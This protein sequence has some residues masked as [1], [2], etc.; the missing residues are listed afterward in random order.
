ME[1]TWSKPIAHHQK[2]PPSSMQSFVIS[3]QQILGLRNLP[4]LVNQIN[5]LIYYIY[6]LLLLWYKLNKYYVHLV[7]ESK[8]GYVDVKSAES[9]G[10]Y[11]FVQISN[12]NTPA[13]GVLRYDNQVFNSGGGMNLKT[14]VFTAPKAGVYTFSFSISKNGFSIDYLEIFLRL[15]GSIIGG[16]GVGIGPSANS[17]AMQSTLKLTKGDRIDLWKSKHGE[18]NQECAYYCHHF[19]G[20]LINPIIASVASL[21]SHFFFYSGHMYPIVVLSELSGPLRRV[22]GSRLF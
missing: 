8:L 17:A 21:I 22:C 2:V 18:L 9:N 6:K 5:C 12:R 16:A 13:Y 19:T 15:N 1:S 3:N 7:V 10:I 4:H 14:G 20:L 11:F